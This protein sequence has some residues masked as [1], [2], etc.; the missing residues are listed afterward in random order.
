LEQTWPC[1][2]D[3]HKVAMSVRMNGKALY[4]VILP[5]TY[6]QTTSL[7]KNLALSLAESHQLYSKLISSRKFDDVIL[8]VMPSLKVELNYICVEDKKVN[9]KR[10]P[11]SI[12]VV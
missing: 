2:D 4:D 8:T 11:G 10:V 12:K 9:L 3:S 6:K 7:T 5:M 1:V